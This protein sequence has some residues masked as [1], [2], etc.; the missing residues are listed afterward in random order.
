MGLISLFLAIAIID[1]IIVNA[2]TEPSTFLTYKDPKCRFSIDY[3]QQGWNVT[4][5]TNRFQDYLVRFD[6][7]YGIQNRSHVDV[8]IL[9]NSTYDI[10]DIVLYNVIPNSRNTT[11]FRN[12]SRCIV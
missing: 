4:A 8:N 2:Q 5:A 12:S 3:P 11:K 9:K 10:R 1:P 6:Q 7:L